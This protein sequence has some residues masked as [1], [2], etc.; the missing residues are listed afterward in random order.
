MALAAARAIGT[1]NRNMCESRS[2]L[3]ASGLKLTGCGNADNGNKT[4]RIAKNTSTPNRTP[5]SNGLET[6]R[7]IR[8]AAPTKSA[9]QPQDSAKC[10]TTPS[11]AAG[12]PPFVSG[13]A[14]QPARDR[15]QQLHRAHAV[16]GRENKREE[17]VERAPDRAADHDRIRPGTPIH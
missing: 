14:E 13:R 5:A 4:R 15:L 3:A 16:H 12:R 11:N 10:A 1:P 8:E 9:A 2:R 6:T 7:G 17:E